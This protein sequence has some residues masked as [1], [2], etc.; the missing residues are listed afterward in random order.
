MLWL[1]WHADPGQARDERVDDLATRGQMDGDGVELDPDD[2]A[3]A[4]PC[5]ERRPGGP[6]VGLAG[7]RTEAASE[8]GA[9]DVRAR[10]TGGVQDVVVAGDDEPARTPGNG[11]GSRP[12]RGPGAGA[13]IERSYSRWRS[14]RSKR[15]NPSHG[16]RPAYSPSS[17]A[18]MA[19]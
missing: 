8:Q 4:E 14:T 11:S 5:V 3:G 19:R 2:V 15:P 7:E 10:G 9:D 17:R 1:P 6:L 13:P 12:S 16:P 18:I